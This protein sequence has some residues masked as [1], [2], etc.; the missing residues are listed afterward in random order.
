LATDGTGAGA[1][2]GAAATAEAARLLTDRR[3]DAI[4]AAAVQRLAALRN[5]PGGPV[6]GGG[7]RGLETHALIRDS[8]SSSAAI[9]AGIEAA[10]AELGLLQRHLSPGAGAR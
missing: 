9:A 1:G 4:R 8:P 7:E 10:E 6:G 3:L 2:A 5:P